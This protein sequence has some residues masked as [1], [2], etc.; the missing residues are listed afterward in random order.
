MFE[1]AVLAEQFESLLYRTQQAEQ[2]YA[3][4]AD[5][6][7]DPQLRREIEQL[8]RDKE[9]HVSLAKRLLEIVQ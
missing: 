3:S 8:R 6:V 7:A 5:N 4:L 2:M 9:R 1:Q